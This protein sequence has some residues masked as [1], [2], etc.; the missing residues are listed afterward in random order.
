M[1]T[2]DLKDLYSEKYQGLLGM[3]FEEWQE[4]GPKSEAEGYARMQEID[5][6]LKATHDEWYEAEG[7][8]KEQMQEFRDRL[9]AEY[10][11]IEQAFGLE[12]PDKNW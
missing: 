3:N 10:D 9:K 7:D 4:N 8:E 12:A 6:E 11:L 2:E 1:D 5:E